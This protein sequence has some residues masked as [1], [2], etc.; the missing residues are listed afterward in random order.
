MCFLVLCCLVFVF[1]FVF[2]FQC[3]FQLPLPLEVVCYD[4]GFSRRYCHLL[5]FQCYF[6][7]GAQFLAVAEVLSLLI[8]AVAGLPALPSGISRD[9]C[10]SGGCSSCQFSVV[11]V[12]TASVSCLIQ[13][14]S[15]CSFHPSSSI[16]ALVRQWEHLPCGMRFFSWGPFLQQFICECSNTVKYP[17]HGCLLGG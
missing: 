11:T 15:S 17:C 8:Q 6:I 12:R 1:V 5:S 13:I 14:Y 2:P 4:F 7:H 3:P 10:I 9:S 16:A